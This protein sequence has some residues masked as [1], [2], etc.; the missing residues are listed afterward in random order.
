MNRSID[1]VPTTGTPGGR[2]AGGSRRI[3]MRRLGLSLSGAIISMLMLA[4]STFVAAGSPWEQQST[5]CLIGPHLDPGHVYWNSKSGK[6]TCKR[7]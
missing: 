1:L 2:R 5:T 4:G 7:D 6:T 3:S